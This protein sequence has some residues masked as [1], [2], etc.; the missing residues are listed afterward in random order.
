MVYNFL[1]DD[2]VVEYD[3]FDEEIFKNFN[4]ES[5]LLTEDM[6]CVTYP[7]NFMLD[8]G[9]YRGINSFIIFV[10]YNQDWETPIEKRICQNINSLEYNLKECNDNIKKIVE[11]Y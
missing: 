9:W 1:S 11:Y 4:A 5:D 7:K 10:I 2:A 6:L 8:V 3:N